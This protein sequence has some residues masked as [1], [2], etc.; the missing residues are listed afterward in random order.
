MARWR[1][2]RAEEEESSNSPS[3][4]DAASDSADAEVIEIWNDERGMLISGGAPAVDALVRRLTTPEPGQPS[5]LVPTDATDALAVF[6]SGFADGA[7]TLPSAAQYF[8]HTPRSLALLAEH[9]PIGTENGAFRSFVHNGT[10]FA[11]NLDW[12]PADLGSQRA[13]VMQTTAI[14]MALRLAVKEVSDA[15]ARVEGQVDRL[16]GMFRSER[17][18]DAVGDHRT[19]EAMVEKVRRGDG[20]STTDWSA[21]AFLGPIISRD[22]EALRAN[23]RLSASAAVSGERSRARAQAGGELLGDGLLAEALATLLV[24]E[25]NFTLWQELRLEQ[26]RSNEPSHLEASLADARSALAHHASEDQALLDELHAV[27]A[28]LFHPRVR[29]GSPP[30]RRGASSRGNGISGC[31]FASSPAS[32]HSISPPP[33]F[34]TGPVRSIRS[35]TPPAHQ[36]GSLDMLAAGRWKRVPCSCVEATAP[37][38]LNLRPRLSLRTGPSSGPRRSASSRRLVR[39]PLCLSGRPRPTAT[40]D[41]DQQVLQS[42]RP[43]SRSLRSWPTLARHARRTTTA[44]TSRGAA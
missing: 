35:A 7:T 20:L 39:T 2:N 14:G 12:Q 15:V 3:S 33:K 13:L 32:E 25:H 36:A 28:E 27:G 42:E 29:D 34:M 21:V 4:G 18:G 44:S 41:N 24:A 16:V 43:E 30:C 26:I 37:T 5:S 23:L 8:Q 31:F 38:D 9:G 40:A 1:K 6:S 10:G 17:L 22:I 19:L 11:G